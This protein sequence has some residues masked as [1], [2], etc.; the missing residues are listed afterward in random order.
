MASSGGTETKKL[1]RSRRKKAERAAQEIERE[2]K[3]FT[4]E[5]E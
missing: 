5:T 4:R 2:K 3:N 1:S